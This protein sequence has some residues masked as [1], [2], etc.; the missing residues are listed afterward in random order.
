M[1][2]LVRKAQNNNVEKPCEPPDR[3]C[4]D[5]FSRIMDIYIHAPVYY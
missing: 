3:L 4:Y 2:P 5:R 1:K